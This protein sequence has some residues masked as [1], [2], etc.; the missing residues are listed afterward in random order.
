MSRYLCLRWQGGKNESASRHSISCIGARGA[1]YAIL[2]MVKALC[3]H[4]VD[5][6][7]ATTDNSGSAV[8]H[9]PFNQRIEYEGVPGWFFPQFPTPKQ[10]HFSV[11]KDK[12]FIFSADLTKWR[13][14]NLRNYDLLE[15]HDLF[16]YASP[17]AGAIA[18]MQNIP[19][20]SEPSVSSHPGYLPNVNSR[21]TCTPSWLSGTT[22]TVPLQF[23]AH[24]MRKKMCITLASKLL[25]LRFY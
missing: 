10:G 18:R 3:S 21:N 23:I 14:Q 1:S 8:L 17:W 2:A 9:V 20:L 12:A 25:R 22:S 4:G 6:E 15:S 16:S 13:W 11:G 5:A 24:Q 19:L 7:I